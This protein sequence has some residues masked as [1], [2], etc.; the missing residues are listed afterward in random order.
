MSIRWL[1]NGASHKLQ[2]AAGDS[3]RQPS[4]SDM[5]SDTANF[6]RMRHCPRPSR[7]RKHEIDA[8][9]PNI[10]DYLKQCREAQEADSF[11]LQTPNRWSY[12]LHL[13]EFPMLYRELMTTR[14][15]I[16]SYARALAAL[17]LGYKYVYLFDDWYAGMKR[18]T[19]RN[20][21]TTGEKPPPS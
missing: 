6:V 1:L 8:T 11:A 9:A 3:A 4:S 13:L 16:Y 12:F 10:R 7:L 21:Q 15:L 17:V 5:E 18:D 19:A 20:A 14:Q 2:F